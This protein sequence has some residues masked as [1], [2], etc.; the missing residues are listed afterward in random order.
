MKQQACRHRAVPNGRRRFLRQVGLAATGWL[1]M[2]TGGVHGGAASKTM[3]PK[4]LGSSPKLR[5]DLLDANSAK[6]LEVI[7]LTA[8]AD[9]PSSH[10]YMEAQ[11]FTPDSKGFVL[12]RS[13]HAH[14]S[15]AKDP[16]H[17]YLL[18]ERGTGHLWRSRATCRP[19]VERL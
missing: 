6:G 19:A 5:P 16:K 18:C 14:G 9:V 13:A 4:P 17:Q 1:A 11:I 3:H 10:V 7:Q 2:G 8:E 12:H 15:D